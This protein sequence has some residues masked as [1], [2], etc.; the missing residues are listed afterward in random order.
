MASGLAK[1]YGLDTLPIWFSLKMTKR[2]HYHAAVL[3]DDVED[4]NGAEVVFVVG[5]AAF[6][7]PNMSSP[8]ALRQSLCSSCNPQA[9]NPL[10]RQPFRMQLPA[11][12]WRW[13]R[14]ADSWQTQISMLMLR[15]P[16]LPEE[17]LFLYKRANVEHCESERA[18]CV[19]LCRGHQLWKHILRMGDH[20]QSSRRRIR[21]SHPVLI[22]TIDLMRS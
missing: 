22:R 8:M 1:R 16:G 7:L 11:K 10:G 17:D 20:G 13:H 6:S 5:G 19:H 9:A 21:Q 18:D 4:I 14:L 12:A 3:T 2:P 15:S